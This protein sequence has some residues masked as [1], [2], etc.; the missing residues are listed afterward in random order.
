M[1][2]TTSPK[3]SEGSA[4]MGSVITSPMNT[5][6]SITIGSVTTPAASNSFVPTGLS[7]A[8]SEDSTP[9]NSPTG[10]GIVPTNSDGSVLIGFTTIPTGSKVSNPINPAT[11]S[12]ISPTDSAIPTDEAIV[13]FVAPAGFQ[14]KPIPSY[15]PGIMRRRRAGSGGFL[16]NP[17]M[18]D[19]SDCSQAMQFYIVNGELVRGDGV[20]SANVGDDHVLL[21]VSTTRGSITTTWGM[22]DGELVWANGNFTGGRAG[23]CR[24]VGGEVYATFKEGDAYWHA[25][26]STC[27]GLNPNPDDELLPANTTLILPQNVYFPSAAP[28]DEFCVP[29]MESWI[30]GQFTVIPST[31]ASGST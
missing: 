20:V 25:G 11:T 16:R 3:H 1:G 18:H 4:S 19:P 13:I 5:Q 2:F 10:A 21:A 14:G 31:N 6:N 24:D 28:T 30:I 8:G 23:F 17:A 15:A 22:V 7:P 29:V 27:P 26:S 12:G 9:L